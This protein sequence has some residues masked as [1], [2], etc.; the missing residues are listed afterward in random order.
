MFE[1]L[2]W[3]WLPVS[4]TEVSHDLHLSCGALMRFLPLIYQSIVKC[5]NWVQSFNFKGVAVGKTNVSG[6]F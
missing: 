6:E 1:P 4:G 5:L 2:Q 3:N